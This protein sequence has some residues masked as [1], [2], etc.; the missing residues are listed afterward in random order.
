MK[1]VMTMCSDQVYMTVYVLICTLGTVLRNTS[2]TFCI[3]TCD[4]FN[5]ANF[6]ACCKPLPMHFSSQIS[7]LLFIANFPIQNPSQTTFPLLFHRKMP[8]FLFQNKC[9]PSA[10][11]TMF[12]HTVCKTHAKKLV[13][14]NIP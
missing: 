12:C 1:W 9:T 4:P 5:L 3:A 6:M 2:Y 13:S 8:L 14:Q 7:H 10:S 11:K